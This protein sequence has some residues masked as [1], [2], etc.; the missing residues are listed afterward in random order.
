MISDNFETIINYTGKISID[1]AD[2]DQR[3]ILRNTVEFN[4]NFPPKNQRR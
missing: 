4:N 3:S 1:E 2:S